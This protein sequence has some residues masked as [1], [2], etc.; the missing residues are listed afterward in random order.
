MNSLQYNGMRLP[1]GAHS[2]ICVCFFFPTLVIGFY[3]N[4]ESFFRACSPYCSNF[5]S[6][7]WFT[8]VCVCYLKFWCPLR[9]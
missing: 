9:N 8:R 3:V 6:S 4:M 7:L 2:A 1:G 5:S